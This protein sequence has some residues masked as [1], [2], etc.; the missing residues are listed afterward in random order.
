MKEW[1]MNE[2]DTV[3]VNENERVNVSDKQKR[4]ELTVL[5][6]SIFAQG[7]SLLLFLSFY[8]PIGLSAL[9]AIFYGFLMP[10]PLFID[11]LPTLLEILVLLLFFLTKKKRNK[12]LLFVS[13]AIFVITISLTIFIVNIDKA[14]KLLGFN[15]IKGK[16]SS[17][18]LYVTICIKV[19]LFA[20]LPFVFC[21]KNEKP[22]FINQIKSAKWYYCIFIG[23]LISLT[24]TFFIFINV[25]IIYIALIASFLFFCPMAYMLFLSTKNAD[26]PFFARKVKTVNG[27]KS[28]YQIKSVLSTKTLVTILLGTVIL[29]LFLAIKVDTYYSRAEFTYISL[30]FIILVPSLIVLSYFIFSD[31]NTKLRIAL[32][33]VYAIGAIL[34]AY[35]F[36]NALQENNF[37]TNHGTTN[38]VISFI[39]T[40]WIMGALSVVPLFTFHDKE[41][42]SPTIRTVMKIILCAIEFAILMVITIS[43]ATTDIN[44]QHPVLAF[45]AWQ[46]IFCA[47][48][49]LIKAPWMK[50]FTPKDE[51]EKE[52]VD[53]SNKSQNEQ[54]ASAPIL[55]KPNFRTFYQSEQVDT[56][57]LSHKHTNAAPT[58]LRT[59]IYIFGVIS[60]LIMLLFSF[61]SYI[62]RYTA[63]AQ[64]LVHYGSYAL[65]VINALI[66]LT[67]FLVK[68]KSS[69]IFFWVSAGILISTC[70]FFPACIIEGIMHLID[71]RIKM[72]TNSLFTITV[73]L[74]I[75]ILLFLPLSFL[76]NNDS[77]HTFVNH[78][79]NSA[80]YYI[81]L[82]VFVVALA[83][84]LILKTPVYTLLMYIYPTF[85]VLYLLLFERTQ[86]KIKKIKIANT[87]E[88]QTDDLPIKKSVLSTIITFS[89]LLVAFLVTLIYHQ[90]YVYPYYTPAHVH[91]IT[92][93]IFTTLIPILSIIC[94]FI[95]IGGNAKL[96][97]TLGI[98]ITALLSSLCIAHFQ[99][100]LYIKFTGTFINY[101]GVAIYFIGIFTVILTTTLPDKKWLPK[102]ITITAKS[103]LI[104][105]ESLALPQMVWH[106]GLA[107]SQTV[108]VL[109]LWHIAYFAILCIIKQPWLKVSKNKKQK[110]Q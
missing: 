38:T 17:V 99:K 41:N 44:F 6:F 13:L 74:D 90:N 20:L 92:I 25:S 49:C 101:T 10:I 86:D 8:L 35:F 95:F 97:I 63:S 9:I 54:V 39:T 26:T 94:F 4:P 110:D 56:V 19:L 67:F 23:Y 43:Y 72:L 65:L 30:S 93:L 85:S 7:A 77:K 27:T 69:P 68:K 46:L 76:Q 11:V 103:V 28:D 34:I 88:N 58:L 75:M 33:A 80:V 32:C 31:G 84:F 47:L 70:F 107:L 16:L 22:T 102:P 12:P 55:S 66:L 50:Y 98:I 59:V 64:S 81:I 42:L 78:V 48:C 91:F 40:F 37:I 60:F 83:V 1:T 5:K 61:K 73:V 89:I 108:L 18:I 52:T 14:S 109:T 3:I 104:I 71:Y 82:A 87:V 57:S 62:P 2:Q 29:M 53:E 21:P 36:L 45:I 24:F 15:E 96:R 51:L 106:C 79:K 105:A 100:I